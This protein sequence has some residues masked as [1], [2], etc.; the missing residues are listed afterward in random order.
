MPIAQNARYY[1]FR[2]SVFRPFFKENIFC[3]FMFALIQNLQMW[4]LLQEKKLLPME[5]LKLE[6]FSGS[7]I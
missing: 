2:I 4:P 6:W 1:G 3:D 5:I 7:I